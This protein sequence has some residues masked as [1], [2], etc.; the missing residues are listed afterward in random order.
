MTTE[1]TVRQFA[2][3]IGLPLELCCVNWP[4][5]RKNGRQITGLYSIAAEHYYV[6]NGDS[7]KN[8]MPLGT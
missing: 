5:A 2:V 7:L 4:P 3:I 8:Q 6:P 1:A